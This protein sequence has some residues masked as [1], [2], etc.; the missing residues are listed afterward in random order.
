M[1]NIP[2][3]P[4]IAKISDVRYVDVA[5]TA[6]SPR[7]NRFSTEALQAM[8]NNQSGAI[9]SAGQ[10]ESMQVPAGW[11]R[12]QVDHLPGLASL[13][14]YNP[15]DNPNTRLNSFYRGQRISTAAAETFKACLAKQP[16]SINSNELKSLSAVLRD[17]AHDFRVLFA[18]TEDLNDKRVLVVEGRYQGSSVQ[19]ITYYVD[20]DSTGSAVQEISYTA[21][22]TKDNPDF[23]KHLLPVTKAFRS[24]VWKPKQ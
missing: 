8:R 24:I 3:K 21:D 17:K 1:D 10:I 11:V 12:R 20:S 13:V 9:I 23:T 16:H 4:N 14:E 22:Q 5:Q 7:E 15:P 2:D 19:S 6:L 18:L